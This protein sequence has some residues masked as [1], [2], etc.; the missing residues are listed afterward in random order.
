MGGE[1]SYTELLTCLEMARD[2][3][4]M[5][6]AEPQDALGNPVSPPRSEALTGIR[7][8]GSGI[9]SQQSAD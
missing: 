5:R 4:T 9:S 2:V 1:F 6:A 3:R 7:G 8:Q